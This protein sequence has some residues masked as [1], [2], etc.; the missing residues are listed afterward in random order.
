MKLLIIGGSGL[1]SG[2]VMD[3]ALRNGI[4]VTVINRG[5]RKRSYKEGVHFIKADYRNEPFMKKQLEG[6]FFDAVIDFICFDK[7][8]LDYSVNLLHNY[9][10]QY[11]FISTSCVYNTAI[12]GIK[13]EN[14]EK[15]LEGWDYSI[16]K[17]ECECLLEKKAKELSFNYT[18]I[19]PCITFDDSRIPYGIMPPYGYHWTFVARI[20]AGKPVIRWEGG[21]TKWNMMRVEDF[22]V[23]VVGVLGNDKAYNEAFNVSG[24]NAYEWNDVLKV[25]AKE[26]GKEPII[27]DMTSVDY[28]R[29]YPA[30]AGEIVGRTFDSVVSNEKIKKIVPSFH[31]TISL[32]DGIRMTL[33]AYKSQNYQHG[34]DWNFDALTDRIIGEYCKK[35][36]I[37][38]KSFN[39]HFIDYLGTATQEDRRTYWLEMKKNSVC[40]RILQFGKRCLSKKKK[41]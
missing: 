10:N 9:A 14:A 16:N 21:T 18:I 25:V 37:D 15:I 5:N 23:G 12:P 27:V 11:V 24:D 35:N 20:L 22:G 3:E 31:Q 30:R 28:Q 6:L 17:W 38:F 41:I 29:L 33:N 34:I 4:E 1:L 36:G 7:Q 19:R 8:Q 32:E 39:L 26:I 40:V 13:D 2:A